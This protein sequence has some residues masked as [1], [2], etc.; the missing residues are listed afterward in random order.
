MIWQHL[1]CREF[2]TSYLL[3]KQSFTTKAPSKKCS[4]NKRT[5]NQIFSKIPP[6][7]VY[8]KNELSH[9]I[10]ETC[11]CRILFLEKT[12]LATPLPVQ[13]DETNS[14]LRFRRKIVFF[15]LKK[16]FASYFW[17]LEA[18]MHSLS[19]KASTCEQEY[20]W[21]KS[22]KLWTS[23]SWKTPKNQPWTIIS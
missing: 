23:I 6:C 17:L 2:I 16:V 19:W 22:N 15:F 8:F 11:P 9:Q 4:K 18:G 13:F 1:V 21:K 14:R 20:L 7:S 5:L 12:G 3:G 10:L